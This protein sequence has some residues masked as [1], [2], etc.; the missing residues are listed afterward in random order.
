MRYARACG[1][2][3]SWGVT[4]GAL[5]QLKRKEVQQPVDGEYRTLTPRSIASQPKRRNPVSL[6]IADSVR[7]IID[8]LGALC[9][10]AIVLPIMILV[11]AVIRISS[12]G[13]A[14]YLQRRL[15]KGGKVFTMFKFRSMSKTAEKETGAVMASDGDMRV[16]SFGRFLRRTRLDELPQLINVLIGDMSLIGPRPERPEIARTLMKQLPDMPRRLEVNAGLSG[17]AQIKAGY[18]SCPESYRKKLDLDIHYVEN[19]SLLLDFKIAV[20]TILVIVTGRGAR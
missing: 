19:R 10:L 15:T 18:A 9:L 1:G 13:P 5:E 8:V 17:L 20:Q 16:T 14:I 7:R 12:P 2:I 3:S 11:A 6:L 4:M